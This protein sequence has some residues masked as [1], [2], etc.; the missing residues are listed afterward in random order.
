MFGIAGTVELGTICPGTGTWNRLQDGTSRTPALVGG[1]SVM[2]YGAIPLRP[3]HPGFPF[4]PR[5]PMPLD[6]GS[7]R[8]L[9]RRPLETEAGTHWTAN[10][11]GNTVA[12]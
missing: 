3:L 7:L 12:L 6:T 4:R 11:N 1:Q 9:F 8:P 2:I 5:R 10:I